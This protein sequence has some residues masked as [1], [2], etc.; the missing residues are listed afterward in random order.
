MCTWDEYSGKS[1]CTR[2]WH[3]SIVG[4]PWHR[5]MKNRFPHRSPYSACPVFIASGMFTWTTTL[6]GKSLDEPGIKWKLN[7]SVSRAH[8]RLWNN[9]RVNRHR[10]P[11]R[12]AF[13]LCNHRSIKF[14]RRKA[15]WQLFDF[16]WVSLIIVLSK[17]NVKN[18]SIDTIIRKEILF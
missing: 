17:K 10:A 9:T 8:R 7:V 1:S 16:N 5:D 6:F 11:F 18:N 15:S 13:R 14:L 2:L 3:A 12:F 4:V